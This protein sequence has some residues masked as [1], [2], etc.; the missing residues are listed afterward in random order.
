MSGSSSPPLSDILLDHPVDPVVPSDNFEVWHPLDDLLVAPGVVPVVVGGEDGCQLNP[1]LLHRLHDN[2]GL[3]G[4]HDGSLVGFVV[5]QE[6]H[7]VVR[8]G[9]QYPH[10]HRVSCYDFLSTVITPQS[11]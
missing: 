6:V 1:L 9:W 2:V 11:H 4:V 8:Q 10:P 3:H 5:H 7:V